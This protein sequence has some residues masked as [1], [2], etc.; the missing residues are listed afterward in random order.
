[1]ATHTNE[2]NGASLSICAKLPVPKRNTASRHALETLGLLI[3]E[4][5]AG[6]RCVLS[7]RP[8]AYVHL[9]TFRVTSCSGAHD[10]VIIHGHPSTPR[11][12]YF[13]LRAN[14]PLSETF[15]LR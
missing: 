11:R 15:N 13:I 3:L 7:L 10:G 12:R 14:A 5:I 2:P 6:V 9:T 8:V 4:S 1:M